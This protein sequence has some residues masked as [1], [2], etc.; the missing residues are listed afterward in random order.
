MR[1]RLILADERLARLYGAETGDIGTISAAYIR[2]NRTD[3]K[4][5]N[6]R[7]SQIEVV[8]Q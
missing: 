6:S 2:T 4:G 5:A 8:R 7:R 1:D 3:A